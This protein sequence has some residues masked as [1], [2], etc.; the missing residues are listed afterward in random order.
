MESKGLTSKI[1]FLNDETI[2]YQQFTNTKIHFLKLSVRISFKNRHVVHSAIST[3]IV[4]PKTQT[5]YTF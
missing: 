4:T 2:Q 5:K 3:N 1:K